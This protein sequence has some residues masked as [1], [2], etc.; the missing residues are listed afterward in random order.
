MLD[1]SSTRRQKLLELRILIDRTHNSTIRCPL[2]C[3]IFCTSFPVYIQSILNLSSILNGDVYKD[4]IFICSTSSIKAFMNRKN[5]IINLEF[6]ENFFLFVECLS[7]L[8]QSQTVLC[9]KLYQET[10]D[11]I[12]L[13]SNI[14]NYRRLLRIFYFY[15]LIQKSKID[16]TIK[17]IEQTN[18]NKPIII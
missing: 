6:I 4:Y 8:Q 2:E 13:N 17:S 1:G 5:E 12:H 3:F 11:K 18:Q 9:L 10:I 14:D 15:Y 16:Q 7:L